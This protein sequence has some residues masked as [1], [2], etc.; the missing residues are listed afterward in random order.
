MMDDTQNLIALVHAQGVKAGRDAERS[1]LDCPFCDD[2]IDLCAA[3][4]AGYSLGRM[5]RQLSEARLPSA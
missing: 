2:R 4:L 1:R 5:G 3:W